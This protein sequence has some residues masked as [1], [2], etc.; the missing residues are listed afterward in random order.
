MER[1]RVD[2]WLFGLFALQSLLVIITAVV[3]SADRPE[4]VM[5]YALGYGLLFVP[6][7]L[8][9]I[10]AY[11]IW[12]LAVLTTWWKQVN[13]KEAWSS[14]FSTTWAKRVNWMLGL[15]IIVNVA[16]QLYTSFQLSG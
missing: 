10:V 3:Q 1:S 8:L 13:F 12:N 14:T 5:N 16:Y 6:F 4:V 9:I 2:C 7:L 15:T 11:V